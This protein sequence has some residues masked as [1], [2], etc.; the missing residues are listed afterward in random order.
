[1][2]GGMGSTFKVLLLGKGVG[3]PAL[4]G[5]SFKVRAT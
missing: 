1:M 4:A 2:P 5:C 3:A